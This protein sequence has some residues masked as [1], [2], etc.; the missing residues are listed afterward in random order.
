MSTVQITDQLNSDYDL[1]KRLKINLDSKH[2][3]ISSST[4]PQ[5][6]A[7]NF[8]AIETERLREE[9][10][11]L[12]Y[13]EIT[14][15]PSADMEDPELEGWEP[16]VVLHWKDGKTNKVYTENDGGSISIPISEFANEHSGNDI[17]SGKKTIR[18]GKIPSID[19]IAKK[20]H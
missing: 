3:L 17:T 2:S 20:I 16:E 14:D 15:F 19:Q 1:V 4:S 13:I 10:P 18:S 8:A 11:Q 5:Q 12:D 7:K 6:Y 9:Y